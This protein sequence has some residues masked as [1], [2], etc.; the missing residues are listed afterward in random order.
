[1]LKTRHNLPILAVLAALLATLCGCISGGGTSFASTRAAEKALEPLR[2]CDLRADAPSRAC[3]SF[4]VTDRPF[5]SPGDTV[6]FTAWLAALNEFRPFADSDCTAILVDLDRKELLSTRLK[7]DAAGVASGSF[8]LPRELDTNSCRIRIKVDA[9]VF[10]AFSPSFTV[11]NY[12]PPET[13]L[14]FQPVAEPLVAGDDFDVR[15]H[16][17]C[18]AGKSAAGRKVNCSLRIVESI[19]T[20]RFDSNDGDDDDDDDFDSYDERQLY[21][22]ST[23]EP[24]WYP[25][26]KTLHKDAVAIRRRIPPFS[27]DY[28]IELDGNGDGRIRIN[29]SQIIKE[30]G[31]RDLFVALKAEL[32]DG[33][34]GRVGDCMNLFLMDRAY[35][36]QLHPTATYAV[37][38]E[39]F[40]VGVE[41]TTFGMEPLSANGRLRLL[42]VVCGDNGS[43]TEKPLP[44]QE[45][46]TDMDGNAVV[47]IVPPEAGHY[48]VLAEVE[49]PDKGKGVCSDM[50]LAW[51]DGEQ[52]GSERFNGV[53]L[54]LD[55]TEYNVG[56]VAR[57]LVCNDRADIPVFLIKYICG[58]PQPIETV[59]ISGKCAVV[60]FT[61]TEKMA[62]GAGIAAYSP[63]HDNK[64][65]SAAVAIRTSF[66]RPLS[67][68]LTP[69][70]SEMR[71]NETAEVL[72]ELHD[73]DGKPAEANIVVAVHD[74]SMD[75]LDN[76]ATTSL[77]AAMNHFSAE[78][79]YAFPDAWKYSA[80]QN[81][82][83]K[84]FPSGNYS[85]AGI[86][87]DFFQMSLSEHD[88][89]GRDLEKF[90]MQNTEFDTV[91]P[92]FEAFC[93]RP[94]ISIFRMDK[95]PLFEWCGE[96]HGTAFWKADIKTDAAGKAVVS[97]KLPAATTWRINAWA[98]THDARYGEN[99]AYI[100]CNK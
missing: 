53:E 65:E 83:W 73:S 87:P 45:F 93:R 9:V 52:L 7:T 92:T 86:P 78:R 14:H 76:K 40:A 46:E 97:F 59:Q 43:I 51:K 20:D 24:S 49:T 39:P 60:E 28:E 69:L 3:S 50:I 85:K 77:H 80:I 1:M 10:D 81:S 63:A 55:K 91:S 70:K 2:D 47:M 94:K 74:A 88:D 27:R 12:A 29:T 75:C 37:V 66:G 68:K 35:K 16:A 19:D 6:F 100:Y 13:M 90:R 33:A 82:L 23:Y 41:V 98:A 71:P 32:A 8:T 21:G 25:A 54:H 96:F 61:V 22:N 18:I 4:V 42:K 84:A 89:F 56:D 95:P 31:R 15:I 48:R 11:G 62:R 58:R 44:W 79:K 17:N 26:W 64:C 36:V 34:G 67:M 57:L 38:G 30:H 72:I 99:I 5:Y